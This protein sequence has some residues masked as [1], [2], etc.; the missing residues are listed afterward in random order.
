VVNAEKVG[1][2]VLH[3]LS[4]EL[5]L[6][7]DTYIGKAVTGTIDEAR[8][9]Q[10]RAHHS[11]THV[12]FASCRKVLGPHVWQNG[13][14]NGIEDAHLDI[15]HFEGIT[16]EQELEIENSANRIIQMGRTVTKTF[17]DKSVAEKQYG[18]SLY[19]GGVVPGNNLRVVDI[20]GI[21]TEACCG[22]HVDNTSEIGWIKILKTTR[23]SDGVVR[24][25]YVAGERAMEELNRESQLLYDMC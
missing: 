3:I 21:D 10:L 24:L 5:P 14:K 23:V 19:Q 4:E 22:T 13:S 9:Q 7:K 1:K 2:C 11:G 16:R 8:R 18:F 15:T 17:V 25:Y 20:E 6:D 12:V